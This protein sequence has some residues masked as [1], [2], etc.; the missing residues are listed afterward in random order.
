MIQNSWKEFAQLKN[1]DAK[2]YASDYSDINANKYGVKCGTSLRFWEKKG[3]TNKIDPCGWFQF[4]FRY[5]LGR[6][7]KEDKR[8]ISRWK[9]IVSRFRSKLVK[10]IRNA[11][12]KYDDFSISSKIRQVLLHWGYEFTKKKF[13]NE[14]SN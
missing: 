2:L 8:Q 10:M 14:L 13:F 1:I 3:W 4:Y 12:S 6:R 5:W 11:G 9:K 7:S